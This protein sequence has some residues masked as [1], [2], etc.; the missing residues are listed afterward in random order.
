MVPMLSVTYGQ[1]ASSDKQT[2]TSCF[3]FYS[4]NSVKVHLENSRGSAS[5]GSDFPVNVT[6][7]NE[8]DYPIVGGSLYVKAYKKPTTVSP[9]GTDSGDLVDAFYGLSNLSIPAKGSVT[10]N[11]IWKVPAGAVSGMYRLSPFFLISNQFD[12]TGLSYSDDVHGAPLDLSVT[13]GVVGSVHFDRQSV[14]VDGQKYVFSS[15]PIEVS[16]A[17]PVKISVALVNDTD[18][19]KT[20]PTSARIYRWSSNTTKNHISDMVQTVVV[21]PQ[22]RTTIEFTL[23]EQISVPFIELSAT[24]G[25]LKTLMGIRFVRKGVSYPRLNFLGL[26]PSADGASNQ[27]FACFHGAGNNFYIAN[28]GKVVVSATDGEGKVL[29][30]KTYQ[31]EVSG[32]MMALAF[33]TALSQKTDKIVVRA[34]SYQNGRTADSATVTYTCGLDIPCTVEG[35]GSGLPV[36][37]EKLFIILA[38]LVGVALITTMFLVLKNKKVN[39]VSLVVFLAISFGMFAVAGGA[40]AKTVSWSGQTGGQGTAQA[41]LSAAMSSNRTSYDCIGTSACYGVWV[42][43]LNVSLFYGADVVDGNGQPVDESSKLKVGDS[44]TVRPL[45]FANDQINWSRVAGAMGTP[46]GYW[47]HK[48]SGYQETDLISSFPGYADYYAPVIVNKPSVSI[49]QSGTAGVTRSGDTFTITSPGS[50]NF[51]V[52]FGG[53]SANMSVTRVDRGGTFGGA[54]LPSMSL[55]IPSQS[56]SFGYTAE[57]PT[58]PNKAPNK[59]SI[60]GPS[61]LATGSSGSYSISG[62]DPDGDQVYYD[63]SFSSQSADNRLPGSGFVNSGTSQSTSNTWSSSGA[64]TVWARTVDLK[65][66]TSEWASYNVAV[67]SSFSLSVAVAGSGSVSSSPSGINCGST[68]SSS[69]NEGASITLTATASGGSSFTGWD[70]DCS[71]TTPTCTV[72]MSK[73]RATTATFAGTK[74]TDPSASNNGGSLPCLYQ[75]TLTLSSSSCGGSTLT[76]GANYNVGTTANFGISVASGRVFVNWINKATGAEFTKNTSGSI[77]M[78]ADT[79]LVAHCSSAPSASLSASP[80]QVSVGDSVSLSGSYS[81]SDGDLNA[82]TIR[83]LGI[84]NYSGYMGSGA[85][86]GAG[87]ESISGSS[88]S[89]SRTFTIPAG[90]PDGTYWFRTEVGDKIPNYGFDWA[91][92][93]VGTKC[94]DSNATN[95]GGSLPC[96]Y[97]QKKLTLSSS[98][99][100]GSTL[101]GAGNYDAGSTANFDIS[102]ASGFTFVRWSNKSTGVQVSSNTSGS[103]TMN[104]DMELVAQC[105]SLCTIGSSCTSGANNCGDTTT[106]KIIAGCVCDAVPPAN[107]TACC[108][109]G[110][111]CTSTGNNCGDTNTGTFKADCSCSATPPANKAL[112]CTVGAPCS[113]TPN[114]CGDYNTSTYQANCSCGASQPADRTCAAACSN[115]G[116]SCTSSPNNCGSTN[117]GTIQTDCSCSASQPADTTCGGGGTTTGTTDLCPNIIGDQSSVPAGMVQGSTGCYCPQGQSCGGGGGGA[118]ENGTHPDTGGI[119]QPTFNLSCNPTVTELQIVKGF[120]AVSKPAKVDVGATKDQ[121]LTFSAKLW[122]SEVG[123]YVTDSAVKYLWNGVEAA[124]I[125]L[126]KSGST[127]VFPSPEVAVKITRAISETAEYRLVVG[128]TNEHGIYQECPSPSIRLNKS[129]NGVIIKEY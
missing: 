85:A 6:L 123:G 97:A 98:L 27:V 101:T 53:T 99:C 94:T 26:K 44:L 105:N 100:G 21:A 121:K 92:V 45:D 9:F 87:G 90:T 111:S 17:G 20:I 47:S 59:P 49:S 60:S 14:V 30:T 48:Y 107:R 35:D 129:V 74:C 86:I 83:S 102:L 82:A 69:F 64:K 37:S 93:S 23:T 66:A 118:C 18:E 67:S 112:C 109:V 43:M 95:N 126:P 4:F 25:S 42:D 80:S 32:A 65:G 15:L 12:I 119:C 55:S 72:T 2:Q 70:G 29:G 22:S 77:T 122:S 103:I 50:I 68:C 76:G 79:E 117:S 16:S 56:I 58:V 75:K 127:S 57:A 71:G 128:A 54:S 120:S 10:K 28:G 52:L 31:G 46:Y 96:T 5:A 124:S 113:S 51:D 84:G 8:N 89:I 110:A 81:D 88:D 91:S 7:T 24:D 33:N 38:A 39:P 1:E 115:V 61:T 78:N 108:T 34:D 11:F 13:G 116:A 62:T 73:A 3:D 106:G 63:V 125:T 114:N 40:D 19:S 41:A 104:A 36:S